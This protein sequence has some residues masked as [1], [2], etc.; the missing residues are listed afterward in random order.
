MTADID[1]ERMWHYHGN[2]RS[3]HSAIIARALE[4]PAVLGCQHY[5]GKEATGANHC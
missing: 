3:H 2:R 5:N 1:K 4:I